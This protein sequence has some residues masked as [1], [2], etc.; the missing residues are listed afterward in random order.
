VDLPYVKKIRM[1]TDNQVRM[2]MKLINKAG[3]SENTARKYRK[4]GKLPSQC[5]VVQG[6]RIRPDPDDW[7]WAEEILENNDGI[8]ARKWRK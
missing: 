5:K 6:W 4:S 3:M 7:R 2:L 8:E 1:V